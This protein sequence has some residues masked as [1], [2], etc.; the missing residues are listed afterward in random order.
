MQG[1]KIR[2]YIFKQKIRIKKYGRKIKISLLPQ[3]LISLLSEDVKNTS[4]N[5]SSVSRPKAV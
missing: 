2:Y 1:I 4:K 5:Y 3:E